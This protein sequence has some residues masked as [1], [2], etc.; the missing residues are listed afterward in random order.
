M[1]AARSFSFLPSSTHAMPLRLHLLLRQRFVH[2]PLSSATSTPKPTSSQ[3][4]NAAHSR[5]SILRL[6]LAIA[7]LLPV[8]IFARDHV[9]NTYTVVGPSM[10][11]LLSPDYAATGAAD[12]VLASKWRPHANL[13]RGMVV[14][15]WAPHAPDRIAIKRVVALEGDA[16]RVRS[17]YPAVGEVMVPPGHVWVEGEDGFK[18]FDSNDFGPVSCLETH[19]TW[20]GRDGG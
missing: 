11:P 18:S 19:S 9:A 3:S 6:T 13:R 4:P 1:P 17:R 5:P 16:V 8:I 2:R 20:P 12:T 10:Q 7:T 14:G 15:F